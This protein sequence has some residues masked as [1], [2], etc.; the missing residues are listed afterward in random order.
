MPW[1]RRWP[2]WSLE[3]NYRGPGRPPAPDFPKSVYESGRNVLYFGPLLLYPDRLTVNL[4]LQLDAMHHLQAISF[5]L[6]QSPIFGRVENLKE[7]E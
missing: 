4:T 3:N 2:N 5:K 6:V 1:E 7:T